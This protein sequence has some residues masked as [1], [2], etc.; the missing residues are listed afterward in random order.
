MDFLHL[1]IAQYPFIVY[2]LISVGAIIEMDFTLLTSG[3]LAHEGYL[4]FGAVFLSGALGSVI[5]D[6]L[7]W[8]LGKRL[9]NTQRKRFWFFDLEKMER[10]L[11]NLRPAT[12]PFVFFSKF[13]WNFNRL[14]LVSVGYMKVRWR[15]VAIHSILA[16]F[17]WS[18]VLVSLGYVFA[19]K[20]AL[21]RQRI[22]HASLI[23]VGVIVVIVIFQSYTRKILKKYFLNGEKT[24]NDA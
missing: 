23:V 18:L 2:P 3:V 5:H 1:F 22:E 17:S 16:S 10:F 6:F 14:V 21:L 15:D 8:A 13:I 12:G 24:Q 19:D 20:T 7:F 4:A 9:A 11:Q